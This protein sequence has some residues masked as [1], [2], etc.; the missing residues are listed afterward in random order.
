M[1]TFYFFSALMLFASLT[2]RADED[3]RWS[4][5]VTTAQGRYDANG[6]TGPE[7]LAEAYDYCLQDKRNTKA[8]CDRAWASP[9]CVHTPAD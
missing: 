8:E 9:H 7:A 5:T 2:A 4:C 3:L 6:A 1:K